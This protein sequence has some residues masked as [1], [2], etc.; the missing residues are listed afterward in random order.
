MPKENKKMAN[1]EIYTTALCPFC[2]G[3]KGLLNGKGVPF[4]EI[5]VSFNPEKRK[6]M[7]D[8]ANGRTSVPQVFIN[9]EHVGGCDDLYDLESEGVLDAKLGI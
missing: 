4:T 8:R 3:A 5:D 6:K 7:T 9:G 2:V 1:I